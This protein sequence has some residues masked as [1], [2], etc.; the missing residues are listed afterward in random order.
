MS[1]VVVCVY[2]STN[3]NATSLDLYPW[4]IV[5]VRWAMKDTTVPL[6]WMSLLC[7]AQSLAKRMS[8]SDVFF[9][10]ART[11]GTFRIVG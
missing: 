4:F 11:I 10:L 7:F 2:E 3:S 1:L 9:G 6:F 5:S 8:Y